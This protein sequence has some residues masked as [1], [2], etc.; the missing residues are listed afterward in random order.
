MAGEM[1][2]ALAAYQSGDYPKARQIWERLAAQGNADAQYRLGY[3]YVQEKGVQKN[4]G[5]LVK[6]MKLAA[7]NGHCKAPFWIG[8][9]STLGADFFT[10]GFLWG[11]SAKWYRLGA[12]RGDPEAQL[13]LAY[14][15]E[16]GEGVLQDYVE[17]AHW[18][19]LAAE[20]SDDAAQESLA[21]M[22]KDG[23]GVQLDFV[24]AHKWY[25]IAATA[26][27][28]TDGNVGERR[29]KK[30]DDLAT[31]MTTSQIAEAHRLAR[32]WKPAPSLCA[33]HNPSSSP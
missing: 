20:Q 32:E 15:Y 26:P 6:W 16:R 13:Y 9:D 29:R 7:E 8:F 3:M 2:D 27:A 1:D 21:D 10:H 23:R 18:Y 31:K 19:E 5:E 28:N 30:R 22:Y 33:Q 4:S 24:Q 12:D 14:Q 25:N 17:A 11:E